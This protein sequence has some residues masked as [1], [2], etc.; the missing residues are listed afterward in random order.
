MR[1]AGR[2]F[3]TSVQSPVRKGR[4]K[5]PLQAHYRTEPTHQ[6]VEKETQY[7]RTCRRKGNATILEETERKHGGR[8]TK[9]KG[10]RREAERGGGSEKV[11]ERNGPQSQRDSKF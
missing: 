5:S 1:T 8:G 3:T 4:Q 2:K 11:E 9:T 7:R 10:G 6:S